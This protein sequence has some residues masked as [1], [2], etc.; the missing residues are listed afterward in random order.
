M[1]MTKRQLAILSRGLHLWVGLVVLFLLFPILVV[2]PVS[3]NPAES[4]SLP[5]GGLS[6]R[7]YQAILE[8]STYTDAMLL[9]AVVA[10]VATALALAVGTMA[11]F[12]LIRYPVPGRSL[13]NSLL[14]SPLVFP[15]V[16]LGVALLLF[17]TPLG[18]VRSVEGLILA[19]TVI[20][21]PYIVRTV[22]ASLEGVNQTIEEAAQSLGATPWETFRHVT[23]PLIRPG[24][25]AG[26]IFSLIMS[27]DEFTVSLFLVGAGVITLPIQVF[28]SIEFTIDPTVAAVST[29]LVALTTLTVIAVERLLGLQHI[30]NVNRPS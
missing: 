1:A 18:L 19:H 14:L 2:I 5:T 23:L 21:L 27:F 7:W 4:L 10:I 13:W 16:V 26:A 25:V 12:A 29:L 28:R 22:G 20:T 17:F 8:Q 30:F 9:S 3:L 11:S 24:V 6:P 15:S